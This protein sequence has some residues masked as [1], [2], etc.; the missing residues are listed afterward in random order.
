MIYFGP[1]GQPTSDISEAQLFDTV[2][3]ARM[4]QRAAQSH[5]EITCRGPQFVLW[6]AEDQ[7]E[8]CGIVCGADAVCHQCQ[9][10]DQTD[11]YDWEV[12]SGH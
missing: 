3:R 12:D 6:R 11:G 8:S 2:P 1:S 5:W 4:V 7:C 10:I 9:H